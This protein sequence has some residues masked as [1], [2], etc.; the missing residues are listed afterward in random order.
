M[1][2]AMGAMNAATII[3]TVRDLASRT[4]DKQAKASGKFTGALQAGIV[5]FT[6]FGKRATKF[7]P[8]LGRFGP[9]LV[10][11]GLRFSALITVVSG[12]GLAFG[13]L[14]GAVGGASVAIATSQWV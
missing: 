9:L 7:A 13:L 12:L 1:Q 14:A 10:K 8:L 4:F 2:G 6:I 5:A 11:L 3:V